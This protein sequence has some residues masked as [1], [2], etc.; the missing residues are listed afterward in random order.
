ML[1]WLRR[2]SLITGCLFFLIGLISLMGS[3]SGEFLQVGLSVIWMVLAV[4]F[5]LLG[6]NLLTYQRMGREN[7]IARLSFRQVERQRFD[8]EM[9]LSE[10]G[11]VCRMELFG[12]E[13]QLDVRVVKW[14]NIANLFGMDTWYRCE[15]I[16]GRFGHVAQY[17]DQFP[18]V[19]SLSQDV[20]LNL[21]MLAQRYGQVVPWV[22]TMYG[23]AN[24]M[25]MADGACYEV[26]LAQQGII[27]RPTNEA[28]K[29]AIRRWSGVPVRDER[30]S[31]LALPG[32]KS[33]GL[34]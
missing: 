33:A 2:A 18:S 15:R 20:G 13:W 4:V 34:R 29:V 10:D 31:R 12:D 32:I 27:S 11:K 9:I 26:L 19:V 21:G 8:A 3:S 16:S 28:A 22:D 5:V 25:P 7:L 17:A 1:I 23:C 14:K 30:K 6:I 24:Y